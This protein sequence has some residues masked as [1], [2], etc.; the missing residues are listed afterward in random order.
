MSDPTQPPPQYTPDGRY[1]WNGAQWIPVP[2]PAPYYYTPKDNTGRNVAIGC[3]IA[4]AIGLALFLGFLAAV[5]TFVGSVGNSIAQA[6]MSPAVNT[7]CSPSPCATSDGLTLLVG[8]VQRSGPPSPSPTPT[9]TASLSSRPPSA[10]GSPHPTPAAARHSV[11]VQVTVTNNSSV[12]DS[13]S[14]YDFQ[15]I[16][17]TGVARSTTLAGGSACSTSVVSIQPGATTPLLTLCFQ[18]AGSPTGP[19]SLRWS[20]GIHQPADIPLP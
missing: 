14:P 5:G 11:T 6:A 4:A 1:W 13:V 18:A 16:D 12:P 20:P 15:L 3:G 10:S 7:A 19:L 9:P 8:T 2:A 17:S